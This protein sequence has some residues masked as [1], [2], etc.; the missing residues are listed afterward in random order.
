MHGTP[1]A[2]YDQAI[3]RPG[4][5]SIGW[6]EVTRFMPASAKRLKASSTCGVKLK[7]AGYVDEEVL[8]IHL[9]FIGEIK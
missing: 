3:L 4:H 2:G 8:S 5:D 1:A 6:V 7:L 9:L